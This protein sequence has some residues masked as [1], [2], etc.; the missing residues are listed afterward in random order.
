MGQKP[1]PR[2]E[3]LNFIIRLLSEGTKTDSDIQDA[4]AN[5]GPEG[6]VP[7][8]KYGAFGGVSPRTLA[9][10]K[11]VYKATEETLGDRLRREFDPIL[12]KAQEDHL[13]EVRGQIE[14]WKEHLQTPQINQVYPR[15]ALPT[16]HIEDNI[17][18][19]S[20]REHLPEEHSSFATLWQD[21][22][23]WKDRLASYFTT[24]QELSQEIRNSWKKVGAEA[25]SSFEAPIISAIA[26]GRRK[27]FW[28]TLYIAKDHTT[29]ELDYQQLDVNNVGVVRGLKTKEQPGLGFRLLDHEKCKDEILPTEYQKVADCFLQSEIASEASQSFQSLKDLEAKIHRSLE[30]ILRGRSYVPG[31]CKRCPIQVSLLR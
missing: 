3:K 2:G 15:M 6:R 22:A 11:A 19:S 4:L 1:F 23:L 20:L 30:E 18:F 17:L 13:K 27:K 16:Q 31:R 29:A 8:G 21:Y 14:L 10:I 5:Y 9:N 26:E 24:C 12:Q 28:Y 25:T 7:A